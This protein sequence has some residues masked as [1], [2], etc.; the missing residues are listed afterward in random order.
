MGNLF[1]ETVVKQAHKY[2]YGK[3]TE[4]LGDQKDLHAIAKL[5][6]DNFLDALTKMH[7]GFIQSTKLESQQM[8]T[9]QS[10]NSE[11]C[12]LMQNLT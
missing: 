2:M 11:I 1:S 10:E 5:L 3:Q 8:E 7:H 6:I 4:K 9:R 12:M